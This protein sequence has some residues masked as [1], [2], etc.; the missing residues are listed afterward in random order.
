MRLR[1]DERSIYQADFGETLKVQTEG[2]GP[3]R[4]I[5]QSS[6]ACTR[7]DLLP[8]E[9]VRT[10][11]EL[12][13]T[14]TQKLS[15]L[16]LAADP[17][18]RWREVARAVA[19]EVDG[20][21]FRNT[22]GDVDTV[23]KRKVESYRQPFAIVAGTPRKRETKT[24]DVLRRQAMHKL[25]GG[26]ENDFRPSP[27]RSESNSQKRIKTHPSWAQWA[28]LSR[29][30]AQASRTARSAECADVEWDIAARQSASAPFSTHHNRHR[31]RSGGRR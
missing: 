8:F 4:R 5:G 22:L 20:G 12:S 6:F 15:A 10:D 28:F 9:Q 16:Q 21:L 19:T 14:D 29:G 23:D 1:P 2:R 25:A 13:K 30:E 3:H 18:A 24:T 27:S 7:S 11:L 17:R 26:R 31:G